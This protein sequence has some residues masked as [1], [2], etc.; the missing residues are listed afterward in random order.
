MNPDANFDEE[1]FYF[2]H[3]HEPRREERRA[4]QDKSGYPIRLPI[5]LKRL[6]NLI[7]S[8]TSLMQ[9]TDRPYVDHLASHEFTSS[10]TLNML[11]L[12]H[13]G[14][15]GIEIHVD[16]GKATHHDGV[17]EQ[18]PH[19]LPQRGR[20]LPLSGRRD[21]QGTHQAVYQV[22]LQGHRSQ[23]LVRK[24]NRTLW[25]R[26]KASQSRTFTTHFHQKPKLGYDIRNVQML[27]W[28]R[29]GL[30]WSRLRN[31]GC[32]RH[33]ALKSKDMARTRRSLSYTQFNNEIRGTP[34]KSTET[35]STSFDSRHVTRADL[36]F[37]TFGVFH[38]HPNITHGA[39][40]EDFQSRI[41]PSSPSTNAMRLQVMRASPPIMSNGD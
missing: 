4:P 8:F 38:V 28:G 17:A 20:C 13:V 12:N 35:P 21:I 33:H 11:T 36:P 1:E 34:P 14:Q 39:A 15:P 10:L 31:S 22:R 30:R 19:H 16:E 24:T 40:Q 26:R 37:A 41:M 27:F 3:Q 25:P 5:G 2:R 7:K 29:E 32:H 23:I 6:K 18:C 9:P